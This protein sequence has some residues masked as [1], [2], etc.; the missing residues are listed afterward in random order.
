[1][2]RFGKGAAALGLAVCTA[3]GLGVALAI[4]PTARLIAAAYT[5]NPTVIAMAAGGLLLACLFF[6]PDCLQVVAAQSLRARGE[7]WLPTITHLASYALVM[8]PLAWF[9]AIPAHMGLSGILC[10]I[11]VASLMSAG[12]L[13][14]RFWMLRRR[15]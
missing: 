5:T 4:W 1:M 8:T 10:A 15:L 14:A 2:V 3:F 6:I 13:L 12:L 11:I 9:L 7:V